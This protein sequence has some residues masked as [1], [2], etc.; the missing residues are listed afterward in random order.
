MAT[1]PIC[2]T[3]RLAILAS[4]IGED[5]VKELIH[6]FLVDAAPRLALIAAPTCSPMRLVHET[7]MLK[8]SAATVGASRMAELAAGLESRLR[9]GEAAPA[10]MIKALD[11]AFLAFSEMVRAM[12][13]LGGPGA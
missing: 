10:P 4:Q 7:H 1:L 11:H 2:D 3:A 8:G 9:A 12:P 13:P 6:T 5:V